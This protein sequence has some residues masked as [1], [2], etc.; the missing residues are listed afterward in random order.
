[1]RRPKVAF[2]FTH[3]IQYFTNLL[4][5]LHQR[6]KLEILAIYAHETRNIYDSGFGRRIEWDNRGQVRCGEALMSDTVNKPLGPFVNSF[7]ANIYGVLRRFKPDIVHINGYGH[8][9]QW[10][11]WLW[12]R[13]NKIRIFVRGDGDALRQRETLLNSTKR[14]LARWFA[15][16][17]HKVFFQG[18]E[19][20]KFWI[21]NGARPE[22]LQWIPCV[23][24]TQ[25]FQKSAFSS[26]AARL[27]FR[28]EHGAGADDLVF[29]VSGKLEPRKR[30]A[31]AI[32]ALKLCERFPA[33]LWFLGSG[34]IEHELIVLAEELRISDR[35]TFWGFRNQTEMP[36]ILQAADVLVHPSERDP[37]P[38]AVLEGAHSGL[39]LLISSCTGSYRDW[40]E[41][42]HAGDVFQGGDIESLAAA[43]RTVINDS[44]KLHRWQDA[45][46]DTAQRHTEAKFCEIFEKAAYAALAE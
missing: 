29:L 45:A 21:A 25:I 13:L 15:K 31:D 34:P 46:K 14:L 10:Q 35:V 22:S 6:G 44:E 19:N 9:I 37:W 18:E 12:A 42:D 5:E 23:S 26:G 7:S 1:M 24:D 33:H 20:K 43:M 2:I 3:R 40:I 36:P 16:A 8:G 41:I 39:A 30:P 32:R 28:K 38:Y 4:D 27:N 11:V 17:A